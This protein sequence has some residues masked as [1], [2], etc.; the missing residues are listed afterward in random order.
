[1]INSPRRPA[2]ALIVH[3]RMEALQM[4]YYQSN[5][6]LTLHMTPQSCVFALL[7]YPLMCDIGFNTSYSHIKK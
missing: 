7:T 1:M 2:L 5:S 3:Q 4:D 6:H